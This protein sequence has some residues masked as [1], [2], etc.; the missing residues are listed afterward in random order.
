MMA[1]EML[2]LRLSFVGEGHKGYY[3]TNNARLSFLARTR[4]LM[5]WSVGCAFFVASICAVISIRSLVLARDDV[6]GALCIIGGVYA[7]FR[8]KNIRTKDSIECANVCS[9]ELDIT[10]FIQ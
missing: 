7:Y 2:C 10:Y 3:I 4:S 8:H 9:S 1:S 5:L 6:S